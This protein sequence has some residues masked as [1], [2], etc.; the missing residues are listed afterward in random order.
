MASLSKFLKSVIFIGFFSIFL[1][2]CGG[3]EGTPGGDV[4]ISGELVSFAAGTGPDNVNNALVS[5]YDDSTGTVITDATVHVNGVMLTY[6]ADDQNYDGTVAVSPGGPVTLT[7]TAQGVT[8]SASGTQFTSYPAISEP[9]PGAVWHSAYGS[10]V[11]WSGED[12]ADVFYGIGVVDAGNPN[13]PLLW[14]SYGYLGTVW[15]AHSYTI[16][17]NSLTVGDRLLLL[18]I[19]KE[20]PIGNAA[21]YSGFIISGFN[22]TPVTVSDATLTSIAV[23]PDNVSIIKG[24]TQQFTATG[25]FSDN[26]T[27]NLTSQVAWS[28]LS[29]TFVTIDSRT[30]LAYGERVGTTLITAKLD[31]ISVY[32][33]ITVL[34]GTLESITVAPVKWCIARGKT[35]QYTATGSFSDNSTMDITNQVT[36]T[37]SDE[38]MVTINAKGLATGAGVGSADITATLLGVSTSTPVKLVAGFNDAVQYPGADNIWYGNTA[39]GDLNGD[40]RNDV[41]VLEELDRSRILVY[42]QNSGGTLDSPKIITTGIAL[43]NAAIADFNGDGLSDLIVSGYSTTSSPDWLGRINIFKQDPVTHALGAPQEYPLSTNSVISMA[44]ADLNGDNLLDVVASGEDSGTTGLLSFLFQQSNGTLGPEVTYTSVPVFLYG[45]LHVADMDNNGLNDVVLQSDQKEFAVI[46]QTSKGVFS[47]TADYYT[48]QFDGIHWASTFALGDVNNDG[49]TDLVVADPMDGTSYL[50]IFLQNAGGTL[51]GPT[52]QTI[53]YLSQDEIHIADMDGDGL[54]D[55]IIL[56]DGHT[57]NILYQYPDHSF[58]DISS[59]HLQVTITG[60]TAAKQRLSIG[61]LTSDG[62]PDIVSAWTLDG[63]YVLSQKP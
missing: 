3:G 7:V 49:L 9:E 17:A 43:K 13:G 30:G 8:Y 60:G 63:I 48:P 34:P 20:I 6:N 23:D 11:A 53:R 24:T 55:I 40:G 51:S 33:P 32:T 5:V 39:V 18:G 37:S 21:P 38:A 22:Y 58:P 4:F 12:S 50:N 35:Q 29:T 27:Q 31:T 26:T 2:N 1:T 41:A 16:P 36:W 10:Y 54:N 42:Y 59:Y 19:A 57:V 47:T 28:A 25:T 56:T 52:I 46:K 15:G 45:E 61:D 14:P 62:L 44:V